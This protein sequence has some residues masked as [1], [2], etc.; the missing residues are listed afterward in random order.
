MK[1]RTYKMY[2][3]QGHG[4]EGSRDTAD[5]EDVKSIFKL[6]IKEIDRLENAIEDIRGGFGDLPSRQY[7]KEVREYASDALGDEGKNKIVSNLR[8]FLK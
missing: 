5:M 1:L 6:V 7:E 2:Y 4:W 3:D 8:K